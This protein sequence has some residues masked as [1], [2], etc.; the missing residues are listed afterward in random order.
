MF[1]LSKLWQSLG[2]LAANLSAL[3]DTVAEVNAGLRQRLA[4]DGQ[5]MPALPHQ[6]GQEVTNGAEEGQ[7]TAPGPKRRQRA[8]S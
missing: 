3:A 8:A 1:A 2:Q 4:L 7:G 5:E 6:T